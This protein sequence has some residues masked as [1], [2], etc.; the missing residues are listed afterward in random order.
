[1]KTPIAEAPIIQIEQT[2]TP[3]QAE[4]ALNFLD[5]ASKSTTTSTTMKLVGN[6]E[7]Q[8]YGGLT[9]LVA[10]PPVIT[11]S[12]CKISDVVSENG[13]I[14]PSFLNAKTKTN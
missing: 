13:L 7:C 11:S 9:P 4:V 3:P 10:P 2:S 6:L 1:L 12:S 8:W 14:S 5:L